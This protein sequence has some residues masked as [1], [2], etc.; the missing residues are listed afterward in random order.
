MKD[1]FTSI[2]DYLKG[3]S[4]SEEDIKELTKHL[5]YW[6]G[7]LLFD[8]EVLIFPANS[9][10]NASMQLEMD[11]ENK[12]LVKF[13]FEFK[14]FPYE[15]ACIYTFFFWKYSICPIHP[16]FSMVNIKSPKA[17][18]MCDCCIEKTCICR[19]NGIII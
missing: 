5:E 1:S 12:N 18:T 15:N 19:K 7:Y 2:I 10:K 4:V 9:S 11:A 16:S 13:S 3:N 6:I 8:D 14:F 17:L